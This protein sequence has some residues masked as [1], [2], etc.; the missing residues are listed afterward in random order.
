MIMSV[1][2]SAYA[3]PNEDFG[4]GCIRSDCSE[5]P[6]PTLLISNPIEL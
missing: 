2:L 4:S 3:A 1:A 5:E 6:L